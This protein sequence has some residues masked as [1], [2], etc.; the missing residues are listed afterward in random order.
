MTTMI[1]PVMSLDVTG[2]EQPNILDRTEVGKLIGA[3]VTA[4]TVKIYQKES[5]PGGRYANHPFPAP[6]G[7]FGRTPFWFA[8]S[9]EK[10]RAWDAGRA[11]PGVG[12]RP[13]AQ[14]PS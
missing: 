7:Y 4:E 2:D 13:R 10:I 6:D 9:A 8:S 1:L 5:K 14:E 11:R 3:G 12:G